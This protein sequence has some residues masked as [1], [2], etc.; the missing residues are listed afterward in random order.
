MRAPR[1]RSSTRCSGFPI[2]RYADRANRRNLIAGGIALWSVFTSLCATA[3]TYGRLLLF[4]VGVGVGEATLGAPSVSLLSDYFPRERRNRA[5]SIY[6]FGIYLG[7]GVAYFIGGLIVGV[8][9]D[10]APGRCR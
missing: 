5:L 1:S 3:A 7:A 10:Q 6:S 2:A 8:V 9:S 4:R